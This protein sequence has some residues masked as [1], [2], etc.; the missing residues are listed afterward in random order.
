MVKEVTSGKRVIKADY[1]IP[2]EQRQVLVLRP[3]SPTALF[4]TKNFMT[5]RAL[6]A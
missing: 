4:T 1:L 5:I 6:M 3:Q 2:D